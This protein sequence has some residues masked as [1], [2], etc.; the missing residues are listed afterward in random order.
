VMVAMADTVGS[1]TE[2]AMSATVAG[3]AALAGEV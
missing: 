3:S 1:T 2:V